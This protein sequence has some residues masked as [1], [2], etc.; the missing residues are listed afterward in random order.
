MES[1]GSCDRHCMVCTSKEIFCPADTELLIRAGL[2]GVEVCV[3]GRSYEH[4]NSYSAYKLKALLK[5]Y[6]TWINN[7]SPIL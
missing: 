7:R 5:R 3:P 2:K 4:M 1:K 6:S